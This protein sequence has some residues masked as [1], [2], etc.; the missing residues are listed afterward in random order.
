VTTGVGFEHRVGD[1]EDP[2]SDVIRIDVG[3]AEDLYEIDVLAGIRGAPAVLHPGDML[4][5]ASHEAH[6]AEAIEDTMVQDIFAPR[7]DDWI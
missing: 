4:L 5:I 7:R 3:T 6:A 2:I 1:F